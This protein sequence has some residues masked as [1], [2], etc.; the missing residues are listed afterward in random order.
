MYAFESMTPEE[1]QFDD[2]TGHWAAGYIN[3]AAINGWIKGPTGLN[4]SFYPDRPIT[5]AE[6]AAI[7]NRIFGRLQEHP[8][9]LLPDMLTWPDNAD[10]N[11]WYYLYIQSATNSYSFRWR[12][13]D[14]RFEYWVA[15]IPPRDWAVLERPDSRAD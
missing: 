4:G 9:D 13:V 8:E 2:I 12:G 15:I 6:T 14:D 5:R 1:N 11:A 3:T 7:V 10:V